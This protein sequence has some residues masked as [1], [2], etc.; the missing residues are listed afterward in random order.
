MEEG[1]DARRE[2]NGSVF[3]KMASR[4]LLN[5]LISEP[6]RQQ[7]ARELVLTLSLL[8]LIEYQIAFLWPGINFNLADNTM[9]QVAIH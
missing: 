9:F 7:Q 2:T 6:H 8:F 5:H 1:G 3:H 4:S